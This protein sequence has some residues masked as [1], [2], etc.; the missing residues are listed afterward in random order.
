MPKQ[1]LPLTMIAL[2]L[3]ALPA[4]AQMSAEEA[5]KQ[6]EQYMGQNGTAGQQMPEA[7]ELTEGDITKL[8]NTLP[9][10]KDLGL[11]SN[12]LDGSDPERMAKA[13]QFNSEA[14]SILQKNGFTPQ[15][16]QQVIYSVGLAMGGLESRGREDEIAG[17]TQQAEQMLEQMEG[18]LTP[19]QMAMMRQ[20]MGTAM[21]TMKRMQDQP[22]G[23][24]TL[25]EKY[26]GQLEA[27]FNAM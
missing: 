12:L 20:Q 18:Q 3:A 2:A 19:E 26:R 5:M 27:L 16:F 21:G 1:F 15:S 11:R 4:A 17:A 13:M 23:N 22:P 9:Q 10:L 8:M 14:L 7:V 6:A 24:L 25:V